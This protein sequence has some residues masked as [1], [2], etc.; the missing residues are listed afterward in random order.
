MLKRENRRLK[1]TGWILGREVNIFAGKIKCV[2]FHLLDAFWD[3]HCAARLFFRGASMFESG[4]SEA[5]KS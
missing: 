1:V 4:Y 3:S 2:Y 5:Y